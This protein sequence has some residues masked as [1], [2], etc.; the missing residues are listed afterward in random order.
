MENQK[1]FVVTEQIR[2]AVI[3]YLATKPLQEVETLVN[4]MRQLPEVPAQQP[5]TKKSK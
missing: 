1:Q 5:E 2:N 4:V 3:Q